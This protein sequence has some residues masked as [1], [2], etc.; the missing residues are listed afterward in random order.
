MT[1]APRNRLQLH[2]LANVAGVLTVARA[3]IALA[4]LFVADQPG[5]SMALYLA[6]LA[7]DVVDGLVARRTGKTRPSP[8]RSR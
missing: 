7:T 4:F 5:P 1:E 8:F 6:G 3:P 2:E